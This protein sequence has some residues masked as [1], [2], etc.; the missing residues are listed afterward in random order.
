MK[1]K[2]K[3]YCLFPKNL[4]NIKSSYY[5]CISDN[6]LFLFFIY[7]YAITILTNISDTL[8]YISEINI[9]I[10]GNGTQ[11]ILSNSSDGGYEHL[12]IVFNSL[13]NQTLVNGVSQNYNEKYVYNLVNQ[14]NVITMRWNY[15]LK[16]CRGMFAELGNIISIDLSNFA[17][18]QVSIFEAMF[19]HCTSLKY[20]NLNNVNTSSAKNMISMFDYCLSLETLNLSSFDTSKVTSM[21]CMFWDCKLLKY[22]DLSHFN[23]SELV[24]T[25]GMFQHCYSLVILN[26]KNFNASK[27]TK[28][29]N[30]FSNVNKNLIYCADETKI[31]NINALLKNFSNN[32][33]HSCFL[34]P[35]YIIETNE[36]VDYC[37]NNNKYS[38]EYNNRCYMSCP[39]GTHISLKK[40][41][42]CDEDI[43]CNKYYN[44]DKTECI[45]EI[46]EGYYLNDPYN[47]TIDKCD[48]KCRNCS[49]E[50]MNQNL[51][52]SCDIS[53]GYYPLY[54]NSNNETFINCYN[55][56]I[57][58]YALENFT[59]KPCFHT[60]YNC[61]EIGDNNNNKC[62]HCKS[63]YEFKEEMNNTQNCYEKCDN[64]YYFDEYNNYIC[65]KTKECP[66]V[67]TKLISEKRKCIDDCSK[68][69]LYIFEYN[70]MCYLT[71][72]EI[73]TVVTTSIS[74]TNLYEFFYESSTQHRI[75]ELSTD[76]IYENSKID[77]L[78]NKCSIYELSNGLCK[79]DNNDNINNSQEGKD[80][81]VSNIKDLLL[82]GA[83]DTI[84]LNITKENNKGLVIKGD[85]ITYQIITIDNQYNC[86]EENISIVELDECERDL[87]SHYNISKNNSL[88]IFKMDIYIE[89]FLSPIIEYE[90]YD[91]KTKIQLDLS[92]CNHTKINILIPVSVKEE[93]INKYNSSHEYYNDICYT[94]TTE[95][96]TDIILADR[97][98]EFIINNMSLCESK[99]EYGGYDIDIKK[100][101]CECEVK[102]KIPLMSE[103]IV[104]SNI[105]KNKIDIKNTMNIKIMKC[106]KFTFSK[107]GLINN[108]G[109]YI[110]LSIIFIVTI[111]LIISLRK[112][113]SKLKHT[114]NMI[115]SFK[116][117]NNIEKSKETTG[118]NAKENEKKKG[119]KNIRIKEDHNLNWV[120]INNNIEAKSNNKNE[121]SYINLNNFPPKKARKSAIYNF[122]NNLNKIGE[123]TKKRKS[124]SFLGVLGLINKNSKDNKSNIKR[125]I[126]KDM[127]EKQNDKEKQKKNN[128]S[129]SIENYNDYE[130]NSLDYH[131]ALMID[132]R[133][134]FQYY[135]SLLRRKHILIFTFYTSNDYNSKEIK[136]CLFLFSFVLYFT[137]NT[138][139]FNDSTM[140]K[141]YEDN[142]NYNI[143]YQLPQIIYSTLIS[144]VINI[145]ATF[146]SLC[147]K[148]ILWFYQ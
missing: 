80:L 8:N 55:E 74:S 81:I 82:K 21:W 14:T 83:F 98:N 122:M 7:F 60:C 27:I 105:L 47:K 125:I 106:Y 16:N 99:C 18:S 123:N 131:E 102:V 36:C 26:L 29:D 53:A 116:K 43:I 88:L 66:E 34:N 9:T 61:S 24:E 133:N 142:G 128:L 68:D 130:L 135:L 129:A 30:M 31:E 93:N 52:I 64:Y 48:I 107:K 136:I 113:F 100:A 138:L 46:P 22:L 87:R 23:T 84:L 145:L 115:K 35:K 103:I 37:Y 15:Q 63:N 85:S 147:E 114:I 90:V 73:S 72:S 69:N 79:L 20:I 140:H 51:C 32:C 19:F 3:K 101:K 121:S 40:N 109:S 126:N 4:Y 62:I 112:G 38:Y 17:T 119:R 124:S 59:F 95:N 141:I 76:I 11:Q 6:Q 70:N 96:G 144:S 54:N 134:Y 92:L 44:Y 75:E 45:E 146:L 2:E 10:K 67:Y 39:N 12:V 104:N 50:S 127:S 117:F 65:T 137:V 78:I 108:I 77:N 143:I 89:G 118:N 56:S 5:I 94:Y 97:K 33:S 86:K 58:G 42:I 1:Q 111:C 25:E 139:F 71:Y 28:M 41:H 13:P 57:V 148:N 49:L 110:I 132:K 91:S 120:N